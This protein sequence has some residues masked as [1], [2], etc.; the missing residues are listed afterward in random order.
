MT[1]PISSFV[2]VVFTADADTPAESLPY[3]GKT[4][5]VPPE[6]LTAIG[7]GP[8]NPGIL[9]GIRGYHVAAG[10]TGHQWLMTA[11]VNNAVRD[12]ILAIPGVHSWTVQA[13]FVAFRNAAVTLIR[14][15]GVPAPTVVTALTNLYSAAVTN[16]HTAA[17]GG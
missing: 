7:S 11:P 9:I 10:P 12:A 8:G 2:G 6:Y 15:F 3:D 4:F 17:P 14:D 16:D 5:L 13:S 1:S